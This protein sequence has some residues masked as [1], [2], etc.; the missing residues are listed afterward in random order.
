MKKAQAN[1]RKFIKDSVAT[2]AG[3]AVMSGLP[4]ETTGA[5]EHLPGG[6]VVGSQGRNSGTP[7]ASRIRFSAIGLNH[8]HIYGQ[9]GAVLRGG[10][11]LVSFYAREPDL[12]AD[13]ARRYPRS[14]SNRPESVVERWP[15][16]R[17]NDPGASPTQ[18]GAVAP[19]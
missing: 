6:P 10:G 18:P 8:G 4:K 1:R 7:G 12:A 16:E 9:V 2:A 14:D 11:Q 19:S 5:R 17:A 13:F 3:I 15:V